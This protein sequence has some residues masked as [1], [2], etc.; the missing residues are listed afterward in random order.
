MAVEQILHIGVLALQG[1]F[2]EHA[3]HLAAAAKSLEPAVTIRTH[4]VRTAAELAACDALVIPG[5]ESTTITL[6]AEKGGLLAPLRDFVRRK[7]T[8]GSCAG[9]IVLSES[10]YNENK[11]DNGGSAQTPA[12][13][14]G[15]VD[16]CIVRNQYGRQVCPAFLSLYIDRHDSG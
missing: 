14:I 15:G 11:N 13:A 4:F 16:I 9:M 3:S 7:P 8:W 6:L 12:Q 5:G 1:G 10:I 2:H